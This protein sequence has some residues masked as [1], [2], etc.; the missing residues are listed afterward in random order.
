MTLTRNQRWRQN[1][2][3]ERQKKIEDAKTELLTSRINVLKEPSAALAAEP[4]EEIDHFAFYIT[5]KL[6][7]CQDIQEF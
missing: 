7:A 2:L 1:P 5:G 3:K 6:K 4:K